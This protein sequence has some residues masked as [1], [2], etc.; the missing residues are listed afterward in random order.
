MENS[1][2]Y[3]IAASW[4]LVFASAPIAG[5]GRE[6]E[7]PAS[8]SSKDTVVSVVSRDEVP[9][10]VPFTYEAYDALLRDYVDER[11]LVDYPSLQA[12]RS[13]LDGF[14]RSMATLSRKAFEAWTE[15]ERL[16]FWINAYNAIT[17]ERII[18]HYPIK[19]GGLIAGLRYPANSIRQIPGVWK[20]LA[21]TIMGEEITLEGIEHDILRVQFREPR[22]HAAIVCAA[23]S[24]PP[25]RNEAFRAERLEEQLDD[26][27]RKFLA[28]E[29]RFRIDL[30]KKRV[31]LSSILDWFGEDFVGVYNTDGELTKHGK[32]KG[33]ALEYVSRHVSDEDAQFLLSS[34]YSVSFLDYDWTLNEQ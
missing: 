1:F 7:P 12:K 33:A 8:A 10:E 27:S 24:C 4:I 5:C 25:L 15:A 16:A 18:D 34:G 30:E 32:T 20:K 22:I 17:L 11:G 14:I 9:E 28:K 6:L 13:D 19:K 23:L 29:T 26:Q 21:N 3:R 31:Y 2:R